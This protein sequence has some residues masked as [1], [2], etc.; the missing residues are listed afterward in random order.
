MVE[1]IGALDSATL[2][3]SINK[4]QAIKSAAIDYQSTQ[5]K[6]GV[7]SPPPVILNKA[8]MPEDPLRGNIVSE[9]S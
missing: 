5:A 6:V 4:A 9:P 8:A 7:D 3:A 2:E 1:G